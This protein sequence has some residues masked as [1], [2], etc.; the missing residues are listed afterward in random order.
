MPDESRAL[1]SLQAGAKFANITGICVVVLG[2]LM[3]AGALMTGG[4]WIGVAAAGVYALL[5]GAFVFAGR[6]L[7]D[8]RRLGAA[9]ILVL[10]PLLG[11]G[12]IRGDW[13]M[14]V[15]II[16]AIGAAINSLKAWR[17]LGGFHSTGAV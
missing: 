13:I 14:L 8:G 15:P 12:A 10:T 6:S 2:A 7:R 1:G 17:H 9:M 4:L 16:P 3:G 5:A 11:F